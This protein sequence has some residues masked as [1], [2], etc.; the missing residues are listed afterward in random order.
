ML[1]TKGRAGAK[2]QRTERA[3]LKKKT[4][5]QKTFWKKSCLAGLGERKRRDRRGCE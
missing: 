5:K 4:K 3:S 2:A 1:Q